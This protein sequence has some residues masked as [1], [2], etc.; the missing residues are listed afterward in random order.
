MTDIIANAQRLLDGATSA[1][2]E[3]SET[4]VTHRL[5]PT[6]ST[7]QHHHQSCSSRHHRKR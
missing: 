2:W 3:M 7:A 1:P 4:E 6:R 5:F